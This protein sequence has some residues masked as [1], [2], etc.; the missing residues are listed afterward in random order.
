MRALEDVI[1]RA[2]SVE[3]LS[4]N[5]PLLFTEENLDVNSELA[6]PGSVSDY[7]HEHERGASTQKESW[8]AAAPKY[9]NKTLLC[10]LPPAFPHPG[11]FSHLPKMPLRDYTF[12]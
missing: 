4:I 1:F 12:E 6:I 11:D 2:I 8:I 9:V 10:F 3:L 7:A 5:L